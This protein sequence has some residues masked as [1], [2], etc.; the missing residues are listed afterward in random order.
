MYKDETL[1]VTIALWEG[2]TTKL[3]ENIKWI[4]KTCAEKRAVMILDIVGNGKTAPVYVKGYDPYDFYGVLFKLN[5][6][7]VWLGD[8][9]AAM[10]VYDVIRAV[11]VINEINDLKNE[12][13]KLYTH[14]NYGI[15]AKL[16]AALNCKITNVEAV[17]CIDSYR[18]WI[19]S[20]YYDHY[21]IMSIVL[22]G[23]LQ[24]FDL[25]DLDLW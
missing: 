17:G 16:A 6:D 5:H 22:P 19:S 10:R 15:Y 12:D 14:G 8:S 2:G 23:M 3:A 13:I 18:E 24:Y 9:L 7:M 20:R 4:R 25:P 1:P 11:D 21:N